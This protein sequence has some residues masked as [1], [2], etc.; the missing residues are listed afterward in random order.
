VA[1]E[2]IKSDDAGVLTTAITDMAGNPER[3]AELARG[4]EGV[5]SQFLDPSRGFGAALRSALGHAAVI[6]G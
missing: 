5:R 1:T 4:C 6:H 3:Y 2:V